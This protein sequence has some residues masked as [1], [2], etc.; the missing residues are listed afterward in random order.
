MSIN[1][2]ANF[3]REKHKLGSA[4]LHVTTKD[5]QILFQC[6]TKGACEDL[7]RFALLPPHILDYFWHIKHYPS[8]ILLKESII[9]LLVV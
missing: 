9:I 5:P 7:V 1:V 3:L 6:K 2:A 4:V 8:T